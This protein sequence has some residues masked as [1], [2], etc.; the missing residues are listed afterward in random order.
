MR[1]KDLKGKS[2]GNLIA[3]EPGPRNNCNQIQW[4]CKCV[5]GN[6]CLVTVGNLNNRYNKSCGC[7]RSE[8]IRKCL[9]L[10]PYEAL[11]RMLKRHASWPV[12]LTYK[13]FVG[14]TNIKQCHYCAA[15]IVWK[16]YCERSRMAYNLDRK[17]NTKG[18]T[19]DNVVVCCKRCN[20]GKSQYFN[21][22]EWQQIGRL[23]S[24][25]T[26]D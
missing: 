26:K 18:Y 10:R 21:Y 4:T 11:Y 6:T 20:I 19:Q 2:F 14:F 3:L 22:E 13:Q 9:R 17:D 5:C 8:G 15:N 16:E 12:K 7:K 25:W 23:I 1:R 24:S